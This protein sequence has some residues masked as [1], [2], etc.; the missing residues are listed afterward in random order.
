MILGGRD[1][2]ECVFSCSLGEPGFPGRDGTPGF[3]GGKGERGDP[4]VQGPPGASLPP[5]TLKGVKG[6]PGLPGTAE[7][8]HASENSLELAQNIKT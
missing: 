3:P 2:D 4:G 7:N 5:S 1:D 8:T 6:D